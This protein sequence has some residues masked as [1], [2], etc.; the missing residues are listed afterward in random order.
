VLP[1][2]IHDHDVIGAGCSESVDHGA[3]QIVTMLSDNRADMIVIDSC[4]DSGGSSAVR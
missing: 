4:L 3:T 1:I 2:A